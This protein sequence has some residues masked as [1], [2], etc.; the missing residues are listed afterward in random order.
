[1]SSAM[2]SAWISAVKILALSGKWT[3]LTELGATTAAAV[4]IPSLDP[5]VKIST[6]CEN[7]WAKL[8]EFAFEHFNHRWTAVDYAVLFWYW[9]TIK[10]R[11]IWVIIINSFVAP[12]NTTL[13]YFLFYVRCQDMCLHGYSVATVH[14]KC[15]VLFIYPLINLSSKKTTQNRYSINVTFL[16]N[17][18][19]WIKG[20]INRYKEVFL[21]G[22]CWN[23]IIRNVVRHLKSDRKIFVAKLS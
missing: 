7:S 5:S 20:L 21:V 17:E 2:F 3:V 22:R 12:H 18:Y 19:N 11:N 1:M 6:W 23:R 16:D 9:G 15:K 14:H 4:L 13:Y 10:Y 8:Q